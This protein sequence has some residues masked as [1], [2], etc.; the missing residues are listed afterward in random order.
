MVERTKSFIRKV[1]ERHSHVIVMYCF[2]HCEALDYKTLPADLAP[3][4]DD[5]LH[6]VKILRQ[7]LWKA[8]YLHLYVMKW[9]QSIA[10]FCSIRRSE[11]CIA[12]QVLARVYEWFWLMRGAIIRSCLQ[13]MSGVQGC[14]IWQIYL[15]IWMSW[16][17][18]CKAEIK[19]CSQAQ[20]E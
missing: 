19:T 18:I 7:D 6:M 9:V 13:V 3:V 8:T 16:A 12:Q 10:P 17:H 2:L 15:S 5:V 20:T 4:L 1:T 11:S 14:H